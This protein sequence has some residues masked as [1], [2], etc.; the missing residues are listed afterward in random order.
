M[1]Q[2]IFTV[3]GLLSIS[4]IN[5]LHSAPTA[6]NGEPSINFEKAQKLFLEQSNI[7]ISDQRNANLE[8]QEYSIIQASDNSDY[9]LD[10]P[11]GVPISEISNEQSPEK[12][13]ALIAPKQKPTPKTIEAFTGKITKDKVRLRTQ[14]SVDAPIL[15]TLSKED[16]LI[17][18][19]ESDDFYAVLPPPDAKAYVFRTYVLDNVIEGNKVNIRSE[20]SL[21]APIIAQLHSGDRIQGTI[22]SLNSKWMEITPPESTRFYVCKE[23]VEKAGDRNMMARIEKRRQ[24]ATTLLSSTYQAAQKESKK[25]YSESNIDEILKN[26]QKIIKDYADFPTQAA[27]AKELSQQLQ[28]EYLHKKLAYLEAQAA[29]QALKAK[30]QQ[31][32]QNK[33]NK[34]NSG[35]SEVALVT[36]DEK[37]IIDR[38]YLSTDKMSIW[39]DIENDIFEEWKA[40]NG[41]DITME[42]WYQKGKDNAIRISGIVEGYTRAVKNKPGDFILLNKSEHLPIAYMYSTKINLQD[43]IGQEMTLLALPR[44]NNHFAF[45]AYY[46]IGIE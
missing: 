39:K 43:K 18:V 5:P 9:K 16:M 33:T 4:A 13:I 28:E 19:G 35:K 12:S 10:N 31:A 30:E 24:E 1:R 44:P 29:T 37:P 36:Q 15:R 14:P 41:Q 11:Q 32:Q 7:S 22:S 20:P 6:K 38:T 3:L 40:A 8:S 23:F 21:D 42:E 45:P 17:V 2:P 26:Y 46:I 25:P 27:R 34:S